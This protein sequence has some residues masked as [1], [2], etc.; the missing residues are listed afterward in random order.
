MKSYE[1]VIANKFSGRFIIVFDGFELIGDRVMWQYHTA[2]LK[3]VDYSPLPPGCLIFN[4]VAKVE[5]HLKKL[6]D[7]DYEQ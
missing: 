3:L 4:D 2:Q 5:E 7:K 6:R 1:S